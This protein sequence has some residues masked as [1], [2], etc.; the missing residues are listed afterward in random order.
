MRK[1]IVFFFAAVCA[2][3]SAGADEINLSG[4][5]SRLTPLTGFVNL[6]TV[7]TDASGNGVKNLKKEDFIVRDAAFDENTG[8]TGNSADFGEKREIVSFTAA[9]ERRDGITFMMLIDDSGSMYQKDNRAS[10]ARREARNFLDSLGSSMD[11]AGLA[12]FGTRY[13]VLAGPRTD[14]ASLYEQLGDSSAPEKE[15]AYTELYASIAETS[16]T[17]SRSREKGR[18]IVILFSDGEN[19]PYFQHSEIGHPLYGE[20]EFTPEDA[21]QALQDEGLTLYAVRFGPNRDEELA[22]IA[23][24]TGGLVF[25][26]NADEEL[27][28]LYSTIRERV[29]SEYRLG[30]RPGLTGADKTAVV[31]ELAGSSASSAVLTYPSGVVFGSPSTGNQALYSLISIPFVFL[32]LFFLSRVWNRKTGEDASLE[33]LR[34]VGGGYLTVVLEPGKTVISPGISGAATT[35]LPEN[36]SD[37]AGSGAGGK[38]SGKPSGRSLKTTPPAQGGGTIIVEKG[39]DG[40]WRISSDDGVTVNNRKSDSTVLENGDVIRAGEELIVFDDGES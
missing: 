30:Y 6:Y 18:L 2:V 35:I 33:R 37:A 32:I 36:S 31:V 20:K 40:R 24:S 28:G 5:D 4:V 12:V 13:R 16:A 21:L 9:G 39:K 1:Y 14:R 7:V 22:R 19:Y 29:L 17:L 10:L 8:K 15:E 25:D 23:G 26:V 3:L 11:R 27:T 34:P 38:F